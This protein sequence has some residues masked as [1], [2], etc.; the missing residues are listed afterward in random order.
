[1]MISHKHKNIILCFVLVLLVL[2]SNQLA[3]KKTKEKI[4]LCKN[5]ETKLLLK[6]EAPSRINK[7]RSQLEQLDSKDQFSSIDLLK[8]I[9]LSCEKNKLKVIHFSKPKTQQE[10]IY[11]LSNNEITVQGRFINTLKTISKLEEY[12]TVISLKFE[13]KRNP[14]TK[15]YNLITNIEFQNISKYEN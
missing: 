11:V 14:K 1:M 7:L 13:K 9:S 5:Y 10:G 3:F 15:K 12:G 8:I 4:K 2:I 6:D